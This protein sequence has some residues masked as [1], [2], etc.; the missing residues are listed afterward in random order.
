MPDENKRVGHD[1]KMEDEME[2]RCVDA[3]RHGIN[4]V[5]AYTESEG[6]PDDSH[7]LTDTARDGSTEETATTIGK[8]DRQQELENFLRPL[9]F[10]KDEDVMKSWFQEAAAMVA[11]EKGGFGV[12]YLCIAQACKSFA[13][14]ASIRSI[15]SS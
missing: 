2:D 11:R 1:A 13:R 14:F 9:E 6:S 4:G 10:P 12:D 5:D 8:K 7:S 3:I 15:S